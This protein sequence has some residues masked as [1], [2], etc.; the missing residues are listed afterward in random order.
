MEFIVLLF[1]AYRNIFYF[2]SYDD[3]CFFQHIKLSKTFTLETS[4]Q[5]AFL[6]IAYW[7]MMFCLWH[8][9]TPSHLEGPYVF[10]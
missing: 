9:R 10:N 6:F 2:K 8:I 5:F 7:P 1:L 3:A 4:Q